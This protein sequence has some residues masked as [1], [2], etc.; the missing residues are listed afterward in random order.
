MYWLALIPAVA[1]AA[2]A[3]FCTSFATSGPNIFSTPPL[4]CSVSEYAVTADFV[5][6]A[7]PATA[8]APT[9]AKAVP[10]ALRPVSKPPLSLSVNESAA[11]AS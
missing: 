9:A 4:N 5:I 7:N 8:A 3:F 2:S 10:T 1:K 6:A 11:A